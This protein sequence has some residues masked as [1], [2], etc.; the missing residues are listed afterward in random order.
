MQNYMKFSGGFVLTIIL[1]LR[2]GL[3]YKSLLKNPPKSSCTLVDIQFYVTI[4]LV[5]QNFFLI[6]KVFFFMQCILIKLF[7]SQIL[8]H[9]QFHIF[10]L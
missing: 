9:P 6:K 10:S 8:P 3:K 1:L 5:T 4:S 2:N 7:S